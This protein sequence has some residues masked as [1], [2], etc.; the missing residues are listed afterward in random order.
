MSYIRKSPLQN[1][2]VYY[3]MYQIE[4]F[5]HGNFVAFTGG[6]VYIIIIELIGGV[7]ISYSYAPYTYHV[8]HILCMYHIMH[9][10]IVQVPYTCT[11]TVNSLMLAGIN[12]GV[13]E[14]K[15]CSR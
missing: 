4:H 8:L 15:P 11:G 12:V 5:V 7:C 6:N 3:H 13:F 2:V 9:I 14:K 1:H 10:P